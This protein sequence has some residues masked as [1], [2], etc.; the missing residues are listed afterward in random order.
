MEA[1]NAVDALDRLNGMQRLDLLIANVDLQDG[2]NGQELAQEV[3][4]QRGQTRLLLTSGD[5]QNVAPEE[6]IAAGNLELLVSPYPAHALVRK[7]R[8]V[9]NRPSD[10]TAN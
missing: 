7:V 1:R 5:T 2:M 9:L 8:E 4:R 10:G 6:R 3:C